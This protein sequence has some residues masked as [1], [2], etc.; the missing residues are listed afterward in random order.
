MHDG[1][2]MHGDADTVMA[3]GHEKTQQDWSMLVSPTLELLIHIPSALPDAPDRW[4]QVPSLLPQ[5]AEEDIEAL[6]GGG[7]ANLQGPGEERQ[8]DK[9]IG[10]VWS[11]SHDMVGEVYKYRCIRK[12]YTKAKNEY[13]KINRANLDARSM[14]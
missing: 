9:G 14:E 8:G 13:H 3:P 11:V 12:I 7:A 1:V 5:A 2:R 10:D 4:L 6:A